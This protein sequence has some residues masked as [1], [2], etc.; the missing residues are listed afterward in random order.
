MY[1]L[2]TECGYTFTGENSLYKLTIPEIQILY[3]GHKVAKEEAERRS[4]AGGRGMT[5]GDKE[6]FEEFAA[7]VE[8][9][10][11]PTAV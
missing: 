2:H 4:D 8:Q 6:A 9:G 5:R 11:Q 7:E 1:W 10:G 3:D